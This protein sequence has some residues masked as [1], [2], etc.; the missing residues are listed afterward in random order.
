VRYLSPD[1]IDAARRAVAG[2][3]QLRLATSGITFT[4]ECVVTSAPRELGAP[5]D[6]IHWH[7]T[8]DDGRVG[9]GEGAAPHPDLR[10]TA[11]YDTAARIAEG[12]LGAQRAFVAGRLRVGGDLALLIRHQ[13]AL[14]RVD[15]ALAPV[16]AETTYT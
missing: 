6:A 11:D 12:E 2:S 1:W 3:D 10:F 9:L 15:D 16:R 8:V 4:I 5:G 14:S 13:K 7:I